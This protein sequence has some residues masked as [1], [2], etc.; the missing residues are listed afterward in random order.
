V[1]EQK[2][3]ILYLGA[4]IEA[5]KAVLLPTPLTYAA[6]AATLAGTTP[7]KARANS[8]LRGLRLTPLPPKTSPTDQYVTVNCKE[9]EEGARDLLL[10]KI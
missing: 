9:V 6:A 4:S 3:L 8:P 7:V 10:A 2:E 5:T 1:E